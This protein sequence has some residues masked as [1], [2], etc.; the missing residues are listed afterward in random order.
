MEIIFII[1]IILLVVMLFMKNKKKTPQTYNDDCEVVIDEYI[2]APKQQELP[3]Q[4]KFLL[5]K[6]EWYFYKKL[7]AVADKYN[8]HILSKVRLADLIEVEKGLKSSEYHKAFSRI[9]SKHIDFVL[10]DPSNLAIKLAI[11]LDDKSHEEITG[12]QRDYFVNNVM[13]KVGIPILRVN[14][15]FEIEKKVCEALKIAQ[16][17]EKT[18]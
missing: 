8:L 16:K 14:S 11:E 15:D 9:K 5:T 10:A 17:T 6:N 12:Q 4:K 13:N 18:F 2:E 7:K 1:I 3:Y